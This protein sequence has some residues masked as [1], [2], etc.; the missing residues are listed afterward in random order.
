VQQIEEASAISHDKSLA[1]SSVVIIGSATGGLAALAVIL[2]KL[3]LSLAASVIIVH[4]MRPGFTKLLADHLSRSS[5]LPVEEAEHHQSLR[6]GLALITPG[7][8]GLTVAK[9]PLPEIPPFVNLEDVSDSVAKSR[10]RVDTA[11]KSAAELFGAK[12]IGVLLSGAGSDGR[13][14]MKAIRDHGGITIAQDQES[15]VL[16][17]MPGAAINASVVDEVLPL[18]NIADRLIELTGGG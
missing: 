13:D 18:W 12:A 14:G 3:P 7:G 10:I 1:A 2:P 5:D 9:N 6:Q 8:Y 16:Y 17:D 15:S 11:M 4:Q